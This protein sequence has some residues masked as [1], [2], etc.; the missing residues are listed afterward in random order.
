M[1]SSP[2]P[3]A[4]GAGSSTAAGPHTAGPVEAFWRF[5][6]W[7]VPITLV[8]GLL[9]GL[10]ALATSGTSTATTTLYLTDPRGAPVFRDG[11]SNPADL[12]RYAS[13]RAD[14]TSSSRP[15]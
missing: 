12:E 15:R 4:S 7:T 9:A 13:Q 14:F 11:S 10:A 8:I 2:L 1:S 5:R 3:T 6:S